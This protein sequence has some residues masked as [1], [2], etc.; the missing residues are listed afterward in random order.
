MGGAVLD[1]G[2]VVVPHGSLLEGVDLGCAAVRN[3][4]FVHQARL[5][6]VALEGLE[7]DLTRGLVGL[8][9]VGSAKDIIKRDQAADRERRLHNCVG[10]ILV[11]TALT[12]F[13]A[14]ALASTCLRAR[15]RLGAKLRNIFLVLLRDLVPPAATAAL[16]GKP[17]VRAQTQDA[18]EGLVSCVARRKR[19]CVVRGC[20]TPTTSTRARGRTSAALAP[21]RPPQRAC[22]PQ[23]AQQTPGR[24]VARSHAA[25]LKARRARLP[26]TRADGRSAQTRGGRP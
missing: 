12:A 22:W 13:T 21:L 3:H 15:L 19:T 17:R 16:R 7:G 2:G 1:G 23:S 24:L 18:A 26:R 20:G 25:A 10:L 11:A 5:Q 4:D 8:G 14:S 6:V 9:L